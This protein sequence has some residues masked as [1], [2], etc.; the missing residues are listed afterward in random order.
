MTVIVT[1]SFIALM[2][3]LAY[4]AFS[5]ILDFLDSESAKNK[6]KGRRKPK[7]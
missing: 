1:L 5:A 2:S 3:V 6:P 4:M 7:I